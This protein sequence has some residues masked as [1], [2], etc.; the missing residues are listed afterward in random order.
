MTTEQTGLIERLRERARIRRQIPTR[1][2]VQEGQPDR[3]ADLLEEAAAELEHA[4][5]S[6]GRNT[7]FSDF[8]RN[9]SPEEKERV[10]QGVMERAAERQKAVEAG[11]AGVEEPGPLDSNDVRAWQTYARSLTARLREMGEQ[12]AWFRDACSVLGFDAPGYAAC[13]PL[14]ERLTELLQAESRLRAAEGDADDEP[15]EAMLAVKVTQQC[16]LYNSQVTI[17]K[18]T[19]RAVWKAMNA[20]A[21]GEH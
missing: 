21:K 3:I 17:H 16:C 8:I 13:N 15:T 9:A 19:L 2:S 10:Y 1:K 20:A 7:K 4:T 12:L 11:A 5:N 18:D 6:A 14:K